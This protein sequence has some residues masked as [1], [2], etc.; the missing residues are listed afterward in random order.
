MLSR[1]IGFVTFML[2][3]ACIEFDAFG[4]PGRPGPASA[5]SGAPAARPVA[6][7]PAMARPAPSAMSHPP[8]MARPSAP[9]MRPAPHFAAPSRPAA[10]NIAASRPSFHRAPAAEVA[11][12]MARPKGRTS[13]YQ[14]ARVRR[15]RCGRCGNSRSKPVQH[16]VNSAS[17]SDSRLC[18]KD[19][20]PSR[21]GSARRSHARARHGKAGSIAYS[22]ACRNCNPKSRKARG[23]SARRSGCCRGRIVSF[24]RSSAHSNATRPVYRSWDRSHNKNVRLTQ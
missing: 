17:R 6:P 19:N 21:K 24:A 1:S 20:K 10:P 23:R 12:P 8:A 15:Q 5:P 7:P 3:L 2:A 16:S 9:A 18:S 4:Q 11:R 22:S 14:L 13:P